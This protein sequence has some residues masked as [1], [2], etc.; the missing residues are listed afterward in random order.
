MGIGK[1]RIGAISLIIR[2]QVGDEFGYSADFAALDIQNIDKRI[3]RIFSNSFVISVQITDKRSMMN[4]IDDLVDKS[5]VQH[6][7]AEKTDRAN[8]RR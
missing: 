6:S 5:F 3:F 7:L 8:R 4:R 1:V 2:V